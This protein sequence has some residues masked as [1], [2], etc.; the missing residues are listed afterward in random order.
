MCCVLFLFLLTCFETLNNI[1]HE[2]LAPGTGLL[3]SDAKSY[4]EAMHQI[5]VMDRGEQDAI[6][7]AARAS[8][9]NRFSEAEF[10]VQFLEKME[11]LLKSVLL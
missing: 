7:T 5:L 10:E 11:P 2:L 9:S 4:A 3:A 6:Q 1:I 8:V